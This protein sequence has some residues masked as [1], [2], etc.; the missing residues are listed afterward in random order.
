MNEPVKF[1]AG[2]YIMELTQ[3]N[4]TK[5]MKNI[6]KLDTTLGNVQ[7]VNVNGVKIQSFSMI[8]DGEEYE[9]VRN[10]GYLI[11]IGGRKIL[12]VGDAKPVKE[13]YQKFDLIN[14]GLDL[15]IAPF[16]YVGLPTARRVIEE[17]IRPKK[18]VAV[19]LPYPNL[20]KFGWIDATM[21]SFNKIKE[22][23][24]ET[25]FFENIGEFINI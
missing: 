17:Y 16:P 8:H 3:K 7:E 1:I 12:H 23:F 25:V 2:I 5:H 24:F 15:L 20:D 21:K 6:I 19:H 9:N 22:K 4:P 13:N 10:L 11:E 18:I 14:K